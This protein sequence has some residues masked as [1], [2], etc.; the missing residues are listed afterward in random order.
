MIEEAERSIQ[1]VQQRLGLFQ[2]GRVEA[3]GEQ[4]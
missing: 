1:F 4:P 2:V 3:F